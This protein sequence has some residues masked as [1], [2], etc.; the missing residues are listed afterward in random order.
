MQGLFGS[1][2]E[3]VVKERNKERRPMAFRS[4]GLHPALDGLNLLR[5]RK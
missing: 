3:I 1:N 2:K 4:G 5:N